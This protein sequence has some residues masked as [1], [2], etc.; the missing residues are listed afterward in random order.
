MGHQEQKSPRVERLRY[1]ARSRGAI[2]FRKTHFDTDVMNWVN[3]G[4]PDEAVGATGDFRITLR[5]GRA[6]VEMLTDYSTVDEARGMVEPFLR[7]WEIQ[8]FLHHFAKHD[9]FQQPLVFEFDGAEVSHPVRGPDVVIQAPAAGGFFYRA[10]PSPPDRFE[11]P[12]D[13][14][15]MWLRWQE[16]Q[17]GRESLPSMA[18][19]CLTVVEA[20]M[21]GARTGRRERAADHYAI[22]VDV[23]KTLGD[24]ASEVGGDHEL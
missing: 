18:Y 13:V 14:R 12:P 17:A 1:V 16:Y 24:L 11:A 8:A 2:V 23:L 19:F 5:E 3:E 22:D 15:A 20:S 10:Y 21:G 9:D 6:T 4:P 7:A